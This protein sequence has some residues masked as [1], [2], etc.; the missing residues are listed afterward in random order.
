MIVQAFLEAEKRCELK[1]ICDGGAERQ[2]ARQLAKNT[3][4]TVAAVIPTL[5]LCSLLS[6]L[7]T[8]LRHIITCCP[9]PENKRC[10]MRSSV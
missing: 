7:S 9:A 10:D 6:S 8:L 2:A 5:E 1:V 4:I 3:T